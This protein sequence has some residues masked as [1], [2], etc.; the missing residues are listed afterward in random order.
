MMNDVSKNYEP[1]ISSINQQSKD[2]IESEEIIKLAVMD[3]FEWRRVRAGET[4]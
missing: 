3:K 2:K 1:L 4:S